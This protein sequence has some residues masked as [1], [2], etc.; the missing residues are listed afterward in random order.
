[1]DLAAE[2][3]LDVRLCDLELGIDGTS[4]GERVERLYDELDRVGIDYKPYV[5]LS[6]DWL[7]PEGATGF[8]I[9]FYLA[10]PRLVRLEH[11]QMLEAEGSTLK[12]CMKLLRHEAAHALD[13]AY[14]LH[15]RTDWRRTFG[16]YSAPYRDA[17]E[18]NPTSK[19]YVQH[20]GAWYAQSHPAEDWAETFS[21]WL[22]P[23]SAWRTVYAGWPAL[24]KLEAL[25]AMMASIRGEKPVVR[26]RAKEDSLPR[27]KKTLRAHYASKKADYDFKAPAR[28][29]RQLRH[30]FEPA[31]ASARRAGVRA[32]RFLRDH[33]HEL[34]SKVSA[35]TG[36]HRY[37]VDEALNGMVR[38][39]RELNLRVKRPMQQ[40]RLGAAVLLTMNILTLS[41]RGRPRFSR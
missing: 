3:L 20:L 22:A 4:L 14:H 32:S 24:K 9:P 7:T 16:A 19:S 35:L 6:D 18:A 40:V 26:T 27:L 10:H 28:Q 17:Y 39:C 31:G 33:R 8:A 41:N 13:N 37:V 34:I 2:E 12:G 5:W 36:G 15:K 21:V 1:V 30:V 38:R 23:K 29:D 25:Q 11:S